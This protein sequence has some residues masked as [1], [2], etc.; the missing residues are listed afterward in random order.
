MSSTSQTHAEKYSSFTARVENRPGYREPHNERNTRRDDIVN[1][2]NEKFTGDNEEYW[3]IEFLEM[4]PISAGDIW[5]K[6]INTANFN[7]EEEAD[8]AFEEWGNEEFCEAEWIH[9]VQV[10]HISEN[11]KQYTW[12]YEAEYE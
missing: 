1:K 6:V 7:T 9:K 12:S 5:Y 11:G 4:K 3:I 8:K 2:V 10:I